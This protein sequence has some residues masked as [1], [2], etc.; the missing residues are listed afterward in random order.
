MGEMAVAESRREAQCERKSEREQS[1][2]KAVGRQEEQRSVVKGVIG[3][4]RRMEMER[5][6]QRS[7]RAAGKLPVWDVTDSHVD[8]CSAN[9]WWVL[10]TG[11]AD[12]RNVLT[13]DG[14]G[15]TRM[16]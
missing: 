14:A 15:M 16:G 13:C 7:S 5:P 8:V 3:W 6:G 4:Q 11:V 1:M 12:A 9:S 2:G 10:F